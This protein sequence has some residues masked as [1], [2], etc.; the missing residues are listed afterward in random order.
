M[1]IKGKGYESVVDCVLF[2]SDNIPR[3]KESDSR[4]TISKSSIKS[5][6]KLKQLKNNWQSIQGVSEKS[7]HLCF[8][9][10]LA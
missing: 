4:E 6:S 5:A 10:F 9:H 3:W 7:V 8:C 1:K 2:L